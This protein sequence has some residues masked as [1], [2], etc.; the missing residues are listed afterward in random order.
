MPDF[1]CAL[2]NTFTTTD[3][4]ELVRHIRSHT[5]EKAFRCNACGEYFPEDATLMDHMES[6]VKQ[7]PYVCPCCPG[8]L[9][10]YLPLFADHLRTH[11]VNRF[12][13]YSHHFNKVYNQPYYLSRR[14]IISATKG[15]IVTTYEQPLPNGEKITCVTYTNRSTLIHDTLITSKL[16]SPT[17][18]ATLTISQTP[19]N[20][21]IT[22]RRGSEPR[23]I[24]TE[25]LPTDRLKNSAE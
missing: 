23:I 13:R 3:E 5:G 11:Y 22:L 20:E 7:T 2:C 1:H 16:T 4:K 10:G 15:E 6:H 17:G 21:R 9:S 14:A 25:D 8:K 12:S 18:T 19:S 24:V